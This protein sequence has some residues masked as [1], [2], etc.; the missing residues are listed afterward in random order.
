MSNVC[1]PT[2]HEISYQ[3]LQRGTCDVE[4]NPSWTVAG[5]VNGSTT[6][7]TLTGLLHNA[8]YNISVRG[9]NSGGIGPSATDDIFTVIKVPGK[10]GIISPLHSKSPSMIRVTWSPPSS[11]CKPEY[12]EVH[13][14][15]LE[16]GMCRA[17]TGRKPRLAGSVPNTTKSFKVKGLHPYSLYEVF[18]RGNTSAGYGAFAVRNITTN[19]TAPTLPPSNVRA[20]IIHPR[21]LV[22]SWSEPTCRGRNGEITGYRYKLFDQKGSTFFKSVNSTV[23]SVVAENLMPYS[24]YSFSVRAKN[25]GKGRAWAKAIVVQTAEDIP[26]PPLDVTV[27]LVDLETLEVEW[28]KPEPPMGKV[29]AYY[30]I[31]SEKGGSTTRNISYDCARTCQNTHQVHR[32]V[33]LMANTTYSVK[34]SARTKVGIG[35][36]SPNPPCTIRTVEGYPSAP[37][38]ITLT[39]PLVSSISIQWQTPTYPKGTIRQYAILYRVVSRP[40][41]DEFKP[42]TDFSNTSIT[43][44]E[45]PELDPPK[46]KVANKTAVVMFDV[47]DGALGLYITN[48]SLAVMKTNAPTNRKQW[49]RRIPTC[50][51]CIVGRW[52][53]SDVPTNFTLGDNTTHGRYHNAPLE[54]NMTYCV[55]LGVVTQEEIY[56]TISNSGEVNS[57]TTN[58]TLHMP[59]DNRHILVPLHLLQRYVTD[60]KT[61]STSGFKEDYESIPSIQLHAWTVAERV[62]NK[63]KNRF[64]N[65]IPYDHSLVK[66]DPME[67][68]PHSEYINASFIDGF[69]GKRNHIAAQGPN[70]AS[71]DDF[72]RMVWQY[73]CRKIVM[74]TKCVESGK[75]KCDKYW[76]DSTATYGNV[77]VEKTTEDVHSHY[78]IREFSVK[79]NDSRRTVV[80]FHYTSWPDMGV[81]EYATPLVKFIRV[82]KEHKAGEQKPTIVHG[83]TGVGRTGT[84]ITLDAML[85]QAEKEGV[86]DVY[87][88]VKNMREQRIKMVQVA[89]QYEFI[90][91]TLME[92]FTCGDT[93]IT[94]DDFH[95]VYP[96]LSLPSPNTGAS[97][98]QEQFAHLDTHTVKPKDNDHQAAKDPA[99]VNKNRYQDKIPTDKSRPCL[100]TAV[101][102]G[103][104]YINA[105]FLPGYM[106]N[107]AYIGTQTPLPHT[108]VDFW[109]LVYDYNITS[110]LML[111]GRPSEHPSMTQYWPEK[112]QVKVTYGPFVVSLVDEEL[113]VNITSRTL[114]LTNTSSQSGERI[115]HQLE[116]TTWP[117]AADVASCPES[118]AEL[119]RRANG[120]KDASDGED[121]PIL[122]HCS[123]GEGAT[124][125][126]IAVSSVIDRIESEK[127]IDVF[128]ACKKLRTVR[129]DAVASLA[130]YE[131]IHAVVKS[132]LDSTEMY[133]NF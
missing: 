104:N 83:S 46:V 55:W 102:N 8:Y 116:L 58:A 26:G 29:V 13:Y 28:Q 4:Q 23:T 9:S 125:S 44:S 50:T 90:F 34:V 10:P 27:T 49:S 5:I 96:S 122:V 36:G 63:Q 24:N 128:Q 16:R 75:N 108:V 52:K 57:D 118:V 53:K 56:E 88:F 64:Q 119:Y 15:L 84:F 43:V 79:Q 101:E 129:Q 73:D 76:P 61:S 99:N 111:N 93:S 95:L 103:T 48:I 110:I 66:L 12:Y 80:Q 92:T 59:P 109:R 3:L 6:E 1:E 112:S 97:V 31:I 82:I 32:I 107:D 70:S 47:L 62:E 60:K 120:L 67:S 39:N 100:R 33:S 71:I 115:V 106:K 41:D 86:V 11:L 91:E 89:E 131:F 30:I 121:A 77:S 65:I 114:H 25:Y 133:M 38:S 42:S 105:S 22:F 37:G 68:E 127:V 98:L 51:S 69:K 40:Y 18:V 113:G 132:Y 35:E 126:F 14:R 94:Q 19:Y 7:F 117:L 130:Q 124:G 45:L 85:D 72:W 54:E 78:I 21:S 17:T 81:P 123:D 2:F 20:T 74:L 87:S